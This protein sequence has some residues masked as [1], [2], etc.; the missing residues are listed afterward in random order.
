[1]AWYYRAIEDTE[2][3]WTCRH[4]LQDYDSHPSA[5]D[6]LEHLLRALAPADEPVVLCIHPLHGRPRQVPV[7]DGI[8]LPSVGMPLGT[9]GSR[10]SAA[11]EAVR[12]GEDGLP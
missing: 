4:G 3:S 1:M 9:S 12:A 6:A 11:V 7:S 5:E 10:W 2:G 8:D